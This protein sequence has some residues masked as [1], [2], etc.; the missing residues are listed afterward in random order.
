MSMKCV[1]MVVWC[2]LCM[3]I[4]QLWTQ[5]SIRIRFTWSNRGRV[6]PLYKDSMHANPQCAADK[7]PIFYYIYDVPND[8]HTKLLKS[9]SK[10]K[11]LFILC[12]LLVKFMK[13]LIFNC[14][15]STCCLLSHC[16]C[17]ALLVAIH[18][19][20]KMCERTLV[21]LPRFQNLLHTLFVDQI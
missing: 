5:E 11:T 21:L 9:I 20:L 7:Q 10:Q 6:V 18:P 1:H 15:F 17:P 19:T 13:T 16:T 12:W 2:L 4:I 14:Q 3:K 8:T